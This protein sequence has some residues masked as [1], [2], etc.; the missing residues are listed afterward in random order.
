MKMNASS[1]FYKDTFHNDGN[2]TLSI[3]GSWLGM[4]RD[5]LFGGQ[6]RFPE[7][8]LPVSVLDIQALTAEQELSLSWLGHSTTLINLEGRLI[9]V[10]PM[11][12]KRASPLSFIGPKRFHETLPVTAED[13]PALDAVLIS[14]DHYDH[15]DREAVQTLAP[16]TGKFYVPLGV[17]AHLRNWGIPENQIV[18]LDWWERAEHLPGLSFV[19][20]PAQ[21]FSG[22][23][24]LDRNRTLWA[25]WTIL[26]QSKRVFYSGDSGYARH[27]KDIG[28]AYG[29]FDLT[30]IECGAYSEYWPSVHMTPE[31]TIQ[32]HL[33][34][35]GKHLVPV[36]WSTFN[37]AIHHWREPMQ[38]AT[39]SASSH[40]LCMTAP[41]PGEVLT[42]FRVSPKPQ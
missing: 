27:F 2:V 21:H 37:L 28:N 19:A 39:A 10:D 17:D 1:Q 16:K 42:S 4:A 31:Q 8:A 35:G 20:T 30:L 24:L 38:R 40:G 3:E 32:A 33:D 36:H 15:L 9:L 29:P 34:L 18:A 6:Q 41:L 22:R 14:H 13:L 7:S 12:A 5:Y 26:G 11:F 23:G 25:S